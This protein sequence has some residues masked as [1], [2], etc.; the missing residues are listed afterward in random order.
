MAEM[1]LGP[2][3]LEVL[4]RYEVDQA[5]RMRGGCRACGHTWRVRNPSG[6]VNRCPGCGTRNQVEYTRYDDLCQVIREAVEL[7]ASAEV[8]NRGCRGQDNPG[9]GAAS[10]EAMPPRTPKASVICA[11]VHFSLDTS[12]DTV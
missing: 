1:K 4:R 3:D 6:K 12:E 10:Q 11:G 8:K 9:G 5:S 7:D 2:S